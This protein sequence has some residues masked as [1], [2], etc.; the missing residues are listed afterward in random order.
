MSKKEI[1]EE[2]VSCPVGKFFVD[3]EKACRKKSKFFKHVNQSRVEFLKAIRSL[4]DERIETFEK[5]CEEREKKTAE[6]IEVR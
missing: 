2:M 1:E 6:K 4:L 5:R 3:M